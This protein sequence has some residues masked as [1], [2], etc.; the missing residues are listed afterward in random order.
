[1]VAV[2]EI[3]PKADESRRVQLGFIQAPERGNA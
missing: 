2:I 1:M 3:G